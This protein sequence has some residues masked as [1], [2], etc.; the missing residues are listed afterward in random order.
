[1]LGGL[2]NCRE[3]GKTFS[4]QLSRG[5]CGPCF[6]QKVFKKKPPE[7]DSGSTIVR[8]HADATQVVAGG[9]CGIGFLLM[10]RLG[11][12]D[13]HA[14]NE[15][16]RHQAIVTGV[17]CVRIP[18][19]ASARLMNRVDRNKVVWRCLPDHGC[20]FWKSVMTSV[21]ASLSSTCVRRMPTVPS[22]ST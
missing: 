17:D 12:R 14:I 7:P 9:C 13:D 15:C 11:R 16:H 1:M 4:D 18:G 22:L 8:V 6:G 21:V 3:C 19:S 10:M 5:L 2:T 20:S